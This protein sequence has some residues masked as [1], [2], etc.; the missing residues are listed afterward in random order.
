M[1]TV[2]VIS[3]SPAFAALD[4][5]E[6]YL[7]YVNNYLTVSAVAEALLITESE[8]HALIN[9]GRNRHRALCLLAPRSGVPC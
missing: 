2:T 7:D 8:A 6:V 4:P 5:V 3:N 1:S 9:V